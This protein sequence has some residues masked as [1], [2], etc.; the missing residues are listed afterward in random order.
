MLEFFSWF[1]VL[2]N[3]K[4][5]KTIT[6]EPIL[7]TGTQYLEV[8]IHRDYFQICETAIKLALH[9]VEIECSIALNIYL[10]FYKIKDH[11]LFVRKY[12]SFYSLLKDKTQINTVTV[13]ENGALAIDLE[14]SS[15]GRQFTP[16]SQY[17]S[18]CQML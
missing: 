9:M 7:C 15:Q 1:R 18:R 10:F 4:A 12:K 2:C 8:L 16:L 17:L 14:E 3:C 5:L 11:E 6:H 13:I